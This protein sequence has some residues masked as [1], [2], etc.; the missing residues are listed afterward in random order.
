MG[1]RNNYFGRTVSRPDSS[2]KFGQIRL[3][4]I[5]ARILTK[6]QKVT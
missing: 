6:P 4:E 2:L 3:P 5:W 1:K